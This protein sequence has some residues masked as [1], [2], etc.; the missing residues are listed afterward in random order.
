M[1]NFI[2][3]IN[4]IKNQITQLWQYE[5]K[6]FSTTNKYRVEKYFFYVIIATDLGKT[7]K[8]QKE[9]L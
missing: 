1:Q 8:K 5:S 4:D 7:P 9:V 3:S 6:T 2:S